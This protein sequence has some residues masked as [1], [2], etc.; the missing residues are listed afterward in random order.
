MLPV[1]KD[2]AKPIDERVEDL[3]SRMTLEEKFTQMRIISTPSRYWKDF[4]FDPEKLSPIA[5]RMGGLYINDSAPAEFI[6]DLQN[7]YLNNTRLGIP[8]A[9][10]GEGLHG[11]MN[12]EAT[13]FTSPL[14]LGASFNTSLISDVASVIGKE[15]RANGINVV[16]APNLDLAREPRWG[17]VEEDYSEDPFL[18]SR[19]G[20]EYIKS[21]QKEGLA[22]CPKHYIAHGTPERGINIAPVHAGERELRDTYALPFEKAF[23]EAHALGVMPAY[24]ELDGVPVHA[25]HFLM[26]EMLRDEFGFDGPA[27]SDWNA[28]GMLHHTHRVAETPVNSGLIAL[29]AGIDVEAPDI[30]GFS[31]ELEERFASGT[32]DISLVDTA[33][34]RVLKLKFRL[35]LFENPY[36]V[37]DKSGIVHTVKNKELAKKAECESAVLLKNDGILPLN[38]NT[39]KV[40][41]IGPNANI[42]QLGD[43]VLKEATSYASTVL[44]ALKN[45]IGEEKVLFE[46]GCNIAFEIPDG[47]K[48]AVNAANE[49]DV[50][51]V[52]LGDNSS[53][54]ENE[55]WADE[56]NEEVRRNSVICGETF[57][58]H[59]LNLP[60]I[61]QKLLEEVYKTGT[62][63]VLVMQSGRPHSI[64][65]AKEHIPAILEAWYPGEMGGEAI[66]DLLFGDENPS[67][68]LPITIPRSAG[69]LPCFYNH[70]HSSWGKKC[71]HGTKEKLG[72]SYVFD[73]MD[74]LWSF[75]HGLSYTTFEYSSLAVTPE[76]IPYDG[77]VNVKVKVKNTGKMKG[78]ESVLLFLTDDVCCVTPYVKR[79]R[80]FEKI[81]LEPNE[82]KYVE[83]TLG[84]DDFY[85]INHN[86]KKQVEAGKFI[87]R[88]A[89]LSAE[90]FIE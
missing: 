43:Y 87:V 60:E 10:H 16:Y 75:G 18:V 89:S 78:K 24:S 15:V 67:G 31:K 48:N 53:Y 76:K 2:S 81:E 38:K 35:G 9:I 63:T 20:V 90:F 19:M 34:R 62:P 17:R 3:L 66:V 21:V 23:K 68:K 14:G 69:H 65:W 77:T 50:A 55:Y 32:E 73:S 83:F 41:L 12:K 11:A 47:I 29:K 88:I 58:T 85:F 13:V 59:T 74:D 4:K 6:N 39:K 64:V 42:T 56:E 40:A 86:M 80:G 8:V 71:E 36:A 27:I 25:S 26:T 51:I 61:Q 5:H 54:Y 22:C 57:D 70:K 1:Y 79:L 28:V 72:R 30:Y 49:A 46:R 84:Y 82:E 37:I 33:V 52:V 45:K 7:Y 44:N